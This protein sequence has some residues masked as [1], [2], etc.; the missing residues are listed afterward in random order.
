[1]NRLSAKRCAGWLRFSSRTVSIKRARNTQQTARMAPSCITTSNS[2]PFSSLKSSSW[3]TMIR[4]PVLEIGRN[5]VSPSTM[6]RIRA[7][8]K[9]SMKI[10]E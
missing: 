1:M 5:S 2:L 8:N 10:P 9:T 3:P 4:W 6:P 7:L